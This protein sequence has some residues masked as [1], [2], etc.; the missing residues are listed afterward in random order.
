MLSTQ[1]YKGV[2]D[3]YPSD[4]KLRNYIFNTWRKVCESFGYEEYDGPFLEPFELYAAKTGDEIVNEQLYSFED[5]GG[6]KVAIRPEMTPTVSRMVAEKINQQSPTPIKWFSIANFYRYE[7]PQKGRKR[8]FFQLNVDIFG[9]E[10]VQ[11][12][13]EIFLLNKAMMDSFG[14][15]S[16]M[17]QIKVNNRHL[18]NFLFEQV[19]KLTNSQIQPVAKAIDRKAKVT[20]EE[21]TELLKKIG[22]SE[23]QVK[24]LNEVLK[25][26]VED[27]RKIKSLPEGAL[28]LPNLFKL[29]EKTNITNVV[30]DP[31][32]VRGFDY[33]DGNIFEQ[34]DMTPGNNRSMFGGGRYDGL[35]SLFIDKRVP[36]TGFAPGDV[37]L[38]DFLESWK[39]IPSFEALTKV[40]V[41]VFPSNEECYAKSLETAGKLRECLNVEI[42]L[43][44]NV[45]LTKQIKYAD[46]KGIPYALI[47]GP[48]E[49]NKGIFTLKN[50]KSGEQKVCTSLEE[51]AS[52]VKS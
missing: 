51:I 1:P 7:A 18:I 8:E 21:F 17:Y 35:V 9:E 30:Y 6:R 12:D 29:L 25:Y 13:L 11:A 31:T 45:D 16:E 41:T 37:T 40:L 19:V 47:I 43:N 28:Q 48:D 20:L 14:A 4:M 15:K 39:L 23:D 49:V 33:Y 50:M 2:R 36:A 24:K 22:L 34:F 3:F 5:R 38:M 32:I 46:R 27:I 52:A 26:T 42:Y 44:P 10:V